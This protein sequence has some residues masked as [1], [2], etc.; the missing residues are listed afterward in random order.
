MRS[1]AR[2]S[3]RSTPYGRPSKRSR[4][5]RPRSGCQR[6]S[7]RRCR[8]TRR[9]AAGSRSPGPAHPAAHDVRFHE[10]IVEASGN[11]VLVDVWRSLRVEART[12]ISVIR[13]DSDLRMIE[14][15]HRP[16][17]QALQSRDPD[18]AGKEMR[19]HIEFFGSAGRRLEGHD[20]RIRLMEASPMQQ[21]NDRVY[22]ET[23][24]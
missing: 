1:P 17:L 16:V 24:N 20:R 8:R 2:N 22:T 9:D 18:L 12:L 10:I 5:G 7:C 11:Q 4:D 14:E 23:T 15:M 3:A 6:R 19:A 21:P 13:S